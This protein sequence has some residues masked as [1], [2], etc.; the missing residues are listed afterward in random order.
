MSERVG[1][2]ENGP[3]TPDNV[4][5]LI[6]AYCTADPW[7]L[8]IVPDRDWRVADFVG[9]HIVCVWERVLCI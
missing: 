2:V 6:L 9:A 5:G 1:G 7:F 3:T 4:D 8:F